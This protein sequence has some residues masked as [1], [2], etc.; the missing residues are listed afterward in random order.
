MRST[1][2]VITTA[3]VAL[4]I[5][6]LSFLTMTTIIFRE[7]ARYTGVNV[8]VEAYQYW[9][10]SISLLVCVVSITN[11]MLIAVYE[12]YNEIGTM[13]CLGALDRHILMLFLLESMIL[14]LM[15]GVSGFVFGGFTSIVT[16]GLQ[17][18]FDNVLKIPFNDIISFFGLSISLSIGLSILATLYPAYRASKLDPV[19]ALS[20]EL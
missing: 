19:E 14:G 17:L 7:Y 15:G 13:K 1:K 8:S 4:G 9:L 6:F 3:S 12:R 16:N 5:A 10:V 2:T 11:S 20:F 18:G